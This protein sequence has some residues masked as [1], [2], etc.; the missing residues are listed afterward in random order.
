[1]LYKYLGFNRIVYNYNLFPMPFFPSLV[2]A[3]LVLEFSVHHVGS[4]KTLDSQRG[5]KGF[6]LTMTCL[7][8]VCH[9]LLVFS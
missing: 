1:M 6:R 4:I 3:L 9:L 8:A 2:G 5:K 7:K